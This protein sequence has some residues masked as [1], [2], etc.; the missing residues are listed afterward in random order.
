VLNLATWLGSLFIGFLVYPYVGN[1]LER[2]IPSLGV[3]NLP[4]AF[5]ITLILAR[6]LLSFIAK[7]ILK[8]TPEEAHHN[9]F[10][11]A[12]GTVPGFINGLIYA[13]LAAAFLMV[14]PLSDN[15]LEKTRESALANK[16]SEQVAWLDAKLSPVFDDA[17]NKTMTKLTVEPGSEK[18]VK[19]PYSVKSPKTRPDLEA[20]MLKMVNE[21]RRKEG[22]APLKADPEMAAVARSHSRDM[23]ARSYFS[24]ITPDGKTPFDRMRNQG[25]RF[26]AAGENLALGQTLQICHTGLMNSPGHRANILHKS[27]GRLGIGVLDGGI[28]GLMITQNFRN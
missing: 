15:L 5:I 17:V 7:N 14:L 1:L 12:L 4:V 24:H 21:E 2:Y 28:Y 25:V 26:L 9:T 27:F 11:H 6:L 23:F 22:L 20:E 13:T 18:T 8:I 3:W 10:N 16:L 19:L